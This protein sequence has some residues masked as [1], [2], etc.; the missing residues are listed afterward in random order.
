MGWTNIRNAI[1]SQ[2]SSIEETYIS[3]SDQFIK[4]NECGN[5]AWFAESLNY[6]FVYNGEARSYE[7]LRFTGV[8]MKIDGQWRFVQLHLSL[9]AGVDIGK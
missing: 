4:L 5:T 3:A 2:F 9:P 6:N 7:G 1:K 8:L